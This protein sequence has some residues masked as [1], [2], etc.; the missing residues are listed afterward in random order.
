M[1]FLMVADVVG[2]SCLLRDNGF[3]DGVNFI[4]I[5]LG[6]YRDKFKYLQDPSLASERQQICESG[7][8]LVRE[9]HSFEARK[10]QLRT[11]LMEVLS[12]AC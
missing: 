4:S 1:G 5:D 10:Q 7:N 8:R 3:E 2:V 12:T 11:L 9:N 6:D